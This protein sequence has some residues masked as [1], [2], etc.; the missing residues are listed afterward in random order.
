MQLHD[1]SVVRKFKTGALQLPLRVLWC[2]GTPILYAQACCSLTMRVHAAAIRT[3]GL[4]DAPR[5]AAHALV[6][7]RLATARQSALRWATQYSCPPSI[8]A[9]AFDGV[10]AHRLPPRLPRE[11]DCRLRCYQEAV[12]THCGIVC[13]LQ[14]V[15]AVDR[16]RGE[17][18][19]ER[20]V[21]HVAPVG[22]GRRCGA[23]ARDRR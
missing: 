21:Q 14:A 13:F 2:E 22:A 3:L 4:A 6:D 15:G 1:F 5:R 20:A 9:S 19:Q 18:A 8:R 12:L 17:R 16:R 11:L 23:A 10:C 7:F